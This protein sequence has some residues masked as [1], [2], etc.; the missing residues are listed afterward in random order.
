[1]GIAG[2]M[3]NIL[4][5][6]GAPPP[7]PIV[8]TGATA[9]IPGTFTPAGAV[10][11]ADVAGMTGLTASPATA[12][13][14]GQ[15]VQTATAGAAGQAHWTSTAWAAGAA[16]LAADA[17]SFDPGEHTVADVL[18]YVEEHPDQKAAVRKAERKGQGRVTLLRSLD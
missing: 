4:Q 16:L 17:E 10:P 13:T 11:P 1:M 6:A 7:P 9:G 2:N 14:A 12:W 15:Y 18:A 3:S 5:S 8:A